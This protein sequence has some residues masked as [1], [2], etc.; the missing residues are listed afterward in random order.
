MSNTKDQKRLGRGLAALIHG[1]IDLP[2]AA[3]A[4]DVQPPAELP[5]RPAIRLI[6]CDSIRPNPFQPRSEIPDAGL[7]GLAGSIRKT[8]LVQPI[9]VRQVGGQ[10]QLIAGER[11]WR[12]AQRAGLNEIQAIVRTAT[13]EDMLE[14][15]LIENIFRED[16]NAI[17]RAKAY[18]RYCEEF[19][20]TAEQVAERIG[21]DRTTVVNYVRLLEL[22]SSV[23]DMVRDGRLSMSHA[24]ALA[25][26]DRPEEIERIAQ[27]AS[28]NFFSVR[29]VEELVRKARAG[30]TAPT[31]PPAAAAQ[32]RPHVRDLEQQ[33]VRAL[34]TKVEI[35]E[36]RKKGT[37]R[38][39]IH[40]FSLD[41]FDR[42]AERLGI[43]WQ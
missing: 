28:A 22:P 30:D 9:T 31:K 13:D 10:F 38:I 41:D 16:L 14:I 12:A 5:Q 26:I 15:A 21:E 33:F 24:R 35:H 8:G 27:F 23:Q 1:T 32:K 34:N 6:R 39:V 18:R 37:G 7:E 43:Q 3:P 29:A 4:Q 20:L 19:G 40:Y 42:V 17:D 11:R 36:S 25:G 2:T